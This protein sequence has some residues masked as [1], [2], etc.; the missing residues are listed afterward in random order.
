M[1]Q[2]RVN[3]PSMFPVYLSA[4]KRFKLSSVLHLSS[5]V[6]PPESESRTSSK[7]L[8]IALLT[9]SWQEAGAEPPAA[10]TNTI[11]STPVI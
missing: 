5:D 3:I 10:E 9:K 6:R 1:L 7:H 2:S 4:E 8:K 11:L